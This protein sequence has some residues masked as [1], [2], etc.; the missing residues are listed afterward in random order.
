MLCLSRMR[1]RGA[2]SRK[3]PSCPPLPP[4][5][6]SL[7]RRC[8]RLGAVRI[9]RGAPAAGRCGRN[10]SCRRASEQQQRRRQGKEGGP[11]RRDGNGGGGQRTAECQGRPASRATCPALP[12]SA[13][14]SA[15]PLAPYLTWAR[16]LYTP[17]C[18]PHRAPCS[19]SRSSRRSCA[20]AVRHASCFCIHPSL[21]LPPLTVHLSVK[22]EII[23]YGATLFTPGAWRQ[24]RMRPRCFRA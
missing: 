12:L 1:S 3:L 14:H 6:F 20:R 5:P 23:S 16:A 19:A 4:H 8:A 13:I 21:S 17:P 11:S 15:T 22:L 24:C 18:T 2:D 9:P 10:A 7:P